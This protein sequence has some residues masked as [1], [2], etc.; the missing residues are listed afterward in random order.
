MAVL[1]DV[2]NSSRRGETEC[3]CSNL[4]VKYLLATKSSIN[5]IN[6]YCACSS[7]YV[8]RENRAPFIK[9]LQKIGRI[10]ICTDNKSDHNNILRTNEKSGDKSDNDI[11]MI[12]CPKFSQGNDDK[13]GTS[14]GN[15]SNMDDGVRL[16]MKFKSSSKVDQDINAKLV[17]RKVCDNVKEIMKEIVVPQMPFAANNM[18]PSK[19]EWVTL[20]SLYK[21]ISSLAKLEDLSSE[22]VTEV[23]VK[24]ET[25]EASKDFKLIKDNIS[26]VKAISLEKEKL[27]MEHSITLNEEEDN[28]GMSFID[29]MTGNTQRPKNKIANELKLKLLEDIRNTYNISDET[30]LEQIQ[31]LDKTRNLIHLSKCL[32]S[33]QE[34]VTEPKKCTCTNI[35]SQWNNEYGRNLRKPHNNFSVQDL[36]IDT[37]ST[38]KCTVLINDTHKNKHKEKNSKVT[39][40]KHVRSKLDHIKQNKNKNKRYRN[41]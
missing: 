31:E 37:E 19:V 18:S 30:S 16:K 21:E 25:L 14:M 29:V 26:Q 1:D 7:N 10:T 12:L 38:D 4:P 5:K 41:K 28:I 24:C 36:N 33:L 20:K 35:K 17:G 40:H 3:N 8:S 34:T 9:K 32:H 13:I 6:Q 23:E 2:I 22:T 11:Q 27:D 15:F 39:L